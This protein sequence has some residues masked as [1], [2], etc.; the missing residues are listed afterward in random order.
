MQLMCMLLSQV[1]YEKLSL[2]S[3]IKIPN[4]VCMCVANLMRMFKDSIFEN[5]I[6]A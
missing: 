6:R 5:L 1:H 3:V 4:M 2:C